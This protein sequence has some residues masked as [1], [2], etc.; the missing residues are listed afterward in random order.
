MSNAQPIVI[1]W[2]SIVPILTASTG[3]SSPP[4]SEL[5][6]PL[7]APPVTTTSSHTVDVVHDD[8]GDVET[9]PVTTEEDDDVFESEPNETSADTNTNNNNNN[10][11]KRRSQS[12]SSLSSNNSKEPNLAKNKERIRRP[13]NAFMIFSKKHRGLVHQRHPNQDNRTVS[14]ILG[15]WWYA[16][17]SEE[18]KKYHELASEVKEAHFKA[19]PEWKWCNKDRRKSSTGSVRSK[20]SSTGDSGEPGEVPMSPRISSP[21]PPWV[22]QSNEQT[23]TTATTTTTVPPSP[24]SSWVVQQNEQTTATAPPPPPPQQQQPPPPDQEQ[25]AGDASDDDQMVICED[26]TNEIDLKCKEKV[27]DSDSE[28][29]SDIENR[30]FQQQRFSPN[31]SCTEITCRPK[32]IKPRLPSNETSKYSPVATT[33]S[34]SFHCSPVNPSGVT[35]FQPT[36]G[37]FKTMPLSPKVIKSDIKYEIETHE[38]W[39]NNSQPKTEPLSPWASSP[40]VNKPNQT[41]AILK[42]QIKQNSIIQ[43]ND[44]GNHYQ[45]QPLTVLIG[46]QQ[47]LCLANDSERTQPFVVVASTASHCVYMQQSLPIPVS[48]TNGRSVAV[49]LVQQKPPPTQSVIV[50]QPQSKVI[51]QNE[52]QNIPA[53]PKSTKEEIQSPIEDGQQTQTTTNSEVIQQNSNQEFKLA[54]TPAQLGKAPLQRRQSMGMNFL[55]RYLMIL[56]LIGDLKLNF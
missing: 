19:H 50:S 2:H 35:A 44:Q 24:P 42:P 43:V 51:T 25:N 13:M 45:S 8:D 49:Q 38:N 52:Y 18:K 48:D 36:G 53:T 33:N 30:S 31:N 1:P 54:P 12:L 29:H 6:P 55:I 37:A 4:S 56:I 9:I 26:G 21:P 34:L 20:L 11:S 39:L 17:D 40:G 27:T 14:K 32:P 41:L 5:S 15:E 10:N 16:L 22:V 7:S 47:T 28:S 46:G 23:S 3:P